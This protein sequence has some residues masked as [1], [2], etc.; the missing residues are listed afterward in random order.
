MTSEEKYQ[1]WWQQLNNWELTI[2]LMNYDNF[3]IWRKKLTETAGK[4]DVDKLKTMNFKDLMLAADCW[5]DYQISK[6]KLELKN[7][8]DKI[9]LILNKF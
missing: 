7:K 6:K 9:E 1:I 4:I 2:E 3:I 5:G 8:I